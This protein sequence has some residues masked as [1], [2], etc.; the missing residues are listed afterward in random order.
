MRNGRDCDEDAGEPAWERRTGESQ[1][2]FARFERYRLLGPER[3]LRTAFAS[4]P[5]NATST[6]E[7]TP[8]APGPHALRLPAAWRKAAQKWN[9]SGR[10]NAWDEHERARQQRESEQARWQALQWQIRLLLAFQTKLA[11]GLQALTAE[12]VRWGDLTAGLRLTGDQLWEQYQRAAGHW[13]DLAG[14]ESGPLDRAAALRHIGRAGGNDWRASAWLLERRYWSEFAR[15]GPE[16]VAPDQLT[17]VLEHVVEQLLAVVPR[18]HHAAMQGILQQ[19]LA[20][21]MNEDLLSQN[22]DQEN[23]SEEWGDRA[24]RD[25]VPASS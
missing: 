11:A 2:W 25:E 9:W 3:S 22:A 21:A 20:K 10:A 12:E 4:E 24:D 17:R 8:R 13:A 19:N 14:T 15:R 5:R 18:E 7:E 1:V 6:V 16:A 23:S